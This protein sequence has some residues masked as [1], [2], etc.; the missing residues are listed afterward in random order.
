MII[1]YFYVDRLAVSPR[2]ANSISRIDSDAPLSA[3]IS[4]EFFKPVSQSIAQVAGMPRC[5]EPLQQF[6]RLTMK[7]DWQSA[8]RGR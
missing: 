4:S 1:G 8:A 2:K 5:L 3:T 7:S 6:G